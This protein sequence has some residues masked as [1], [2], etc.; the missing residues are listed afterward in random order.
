MAKEPIPE[1]WKS[2]PSIGGKQPGQEQGPPQPCQFMG[3]GYPPDFIE[4][5]ITLISVPGH[6]DFYT[7]APVAIE[8]DMVGVVQAFSYDEKEEIVIQ[9]R[10][11]TFVKVAGIVSYLVK[12]P[13]WWNEVLEKKTELPE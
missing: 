13:E 11:L 8:P 9:Y 5:L 12:P 2:L 6:G 3:I 4:G 1:N 7:N 10:L